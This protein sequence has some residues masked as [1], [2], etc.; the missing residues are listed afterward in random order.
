MS[1]NKLLFWVCRVATFSGNME[2]SEIHFNFYRK[3]WSKIVLVKYFTVQK[4]RLKIH[5][6]IWS[7]HLENNIVDLTKLFCL[8]N[9][10]F[11]LNQIKL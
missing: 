9:L 7:K 1:V 3:I 4:Y 6:N 2:K 8:M 11:C 5:K 10:D